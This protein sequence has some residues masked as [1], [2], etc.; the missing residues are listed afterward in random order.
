M[1]K[2]SV[3]ECTA[4][5]DQQ[6]NCAVLLSMIAWLRFRAFDDAD[7][8]YRTHFLHIASQQ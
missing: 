7:D 8:R 3:H 2:F 6:L 5:M 4:W 1:M